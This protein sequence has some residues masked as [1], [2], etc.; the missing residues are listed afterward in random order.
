MAWVRGVLSQTVVSTV[1]LHKRCLPPV[2]IAYEWLHI[3]CRV[4]AWYTSS[5][6]E[7]TAVPQAITTPTVAGWTK[8][9]WSMPGLPTDLREVLLLLLLLCCRLARMTRCSSWPTSC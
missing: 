6:I 9:A 7:T 3:F 8:G 4:I 1:C 2:L 5:L